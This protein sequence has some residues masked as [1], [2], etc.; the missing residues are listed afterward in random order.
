LFARVLQDAWAFLW[1]EGSALTHEKIDMARRTVLG[2]GG[3]VDL[4]RGA[5]LAVEQ[6]L[7]TMRRADTP[8]TG[9]TPIDLAIPGEATAGGWHVTARVGTGSTEDGGAWRAMVDA[10]AIGRIACVRSRLAGDRFQPLG[11]ANEVRLP[12]VLVN[13]RVPRSLRAGLPL[14]V[15]VRGIAWVPGVRI[16]E[17]AK[18]TPD[19]TRAI[20]MEVRLV[21]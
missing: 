12:D 2:R 17:W 4:G 1:G 5:A 13:A 21:N 7:T 10:A 14:L 18:V 8:T 19:T 11:M 15:G 6:D 3:M 16:A 9:F 20:A